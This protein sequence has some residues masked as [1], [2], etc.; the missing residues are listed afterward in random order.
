MDVQSPAFDVPHGTVSLKCDE[1]EAF[2]AL[3]ARVTPSV[4]EVCRCPKNVQH[5]ADVI[6]VGN[7]LKLKRWDTNVV[8]CK[9][10]EFLFGW[11][12]LTSQCMWAGYM[13]WCRLRQEY[14]EILEEGE[15]DLE[16]S[17]LAFTQHQKR[18]DA[19]LELGVECL[20][21]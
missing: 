9:C 2:Y 13:A 16:G 18:R 14:E 1:S 19:C 17:K 8:P 12:V 3:A 5:P 4:I 6:W 15:L 11:D 7:K 21:G 10:P 20:Q